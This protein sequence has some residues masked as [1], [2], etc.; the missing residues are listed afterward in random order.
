MKKT[1]VAVIIISLFAL[2]ACGQ[3]ASES[4]SSGGASVV[5]DIF[6]GGEAVDLTVYKSMKDSK[7]ES[8]FVDIE[9]KDI[10]KLMDEK[11]TFVFMATFIDCPYCN[12]VIPYVNEAAKKN[13]LHIGY[14]DTRKDPKWENNTE[15]KDYDICTK[16]FGEYLKKDNDGTPHLYTPHTF[17]IKEGKVVA[18]HQGVIDGADDT[19]ADLTGGQ[20][21]DLRLLLD[22]EFEKL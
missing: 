15:I 17:F 4:Q 16:Y 21:A 13:G 12:M 11:K 20:E 7:E 5:E 8:R 2:S 3:K 22:Q 9:V 19:E 1:V 18:N 14:L 6:A 10:A